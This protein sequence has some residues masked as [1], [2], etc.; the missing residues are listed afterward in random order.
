MSKYMLDELTQKK[1]CLGH[2]LQFYNSQYNLDYELGQIIYKYLYVLNVI[3]QKYIFQD[4]SYPPKRLT[5]LF[6]NHC[7]FCVEFENSTN[8]INLIDLKNDYNIIYTTGW[9]SCILCYNIAIKN[10]KYLSF[11]IKHLFKDN[12]F[13]IKRSSGKLEKGW[14]ISGNA[15]RLNINDNF[16]VL[17]KS[18]DFQKCVYVLELIKWQYV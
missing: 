1:L 8:S 18:K 10:R 14:A 6:I 4:K 7:D 9:Q 3:R 17:I 11:S 15:Y 12:E 16:I 2:I 5:S 13:L